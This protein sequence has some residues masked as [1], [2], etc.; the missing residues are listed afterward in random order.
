[1]EHFTE[2]SH[3]I[4]RRSH[5]LQI[6]ESKRLTNLLKDLGRQQK[7][8]PTRKPMSADLNLKALYLLY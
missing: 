5:K 1:M 7:G 3:S 2:Y 6:S 8:K 4:L